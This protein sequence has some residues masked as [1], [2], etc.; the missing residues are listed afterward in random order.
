MTN[1][2]NTKRFY[3]IFLMLFIAGA[4]FLRL[5]VSAAAGAKWDGY[6]KISS[7]ADILKMDGS[8]G[9]FYLAKDIDMKKLGNWDKEITFSGTLDGNGYCIKNLT[10]DKYGLF[11]ELSDATIQ[12]LGLTNVKIKS[13]IM[14][15]GALTRIC[16]NTAISNCYVT[17]SVES[18]AEYGTATGFVGGIFWGNHFTDCVNMADIS[19]YFAYGISGS[20]STDTYVNCINYGKITG[21]KAA[22]GICRELSSEMKSCCNLGEISASADDGQA[23]GIAYKVSDKASMKNCATVTSSDIGERGDGCTAKADT[24]VSESVFKKSSTYKGFDFK[25]TWAISKK[26]NSEKPVLAIMLRNYNGSKPVAD[27]AAGTYK[28][29]VKVKLSTDIKGGIIRYTI[30]GNAPSV[31]SEKYSKPLTLKKS[32]TIKAAVFVGEVRAKTAEFKYIIK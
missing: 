14:E 7:P 13:E 17:G 21:E 26:V 24:D 10:S 2:K 28:K 8:N 31:K 29:S 12:N 3:R 18:S 16:K 9:K 4:L 25:K 27:K 30:N 1:S 5:P 20:D 6:T 15:I 32:A 22:A 19:G 11:S 23:G